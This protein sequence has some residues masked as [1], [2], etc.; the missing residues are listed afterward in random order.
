MSP[1][2][3]NLT[4]DEREAWRAAIAEAASMDAT[5]TQQGEALAAHLLLHLDRRELWA[6]RIVKALLVRACRSLVKEH[7]KR[8]NRLTLA[9]NGE[10]V[11]RT[12]AA[13]VTRP[14]GGKQ[15][16]LFVE[17]TW[18]QLS[19]WINAEQT[20]RIGAEQNIAAARQF[21]A[22]RDLAPGT[23]TPAEALDVLGQ[24]IDDVLAS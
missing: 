3:R 18:E 1:L 2:E 9:W 7:A 15:L 17:M 12:A 20:R 21:L 4:D 24:S 10:L 19:E 11:D 16:V 23:A 5:T 13:S 6:V 22:L 14:D 8:V